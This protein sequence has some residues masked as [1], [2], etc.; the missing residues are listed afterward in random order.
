MDLER[1]GS[2]EWCQCAKEVLR[3]LQCDSEWILLR[4]PDRFKNSHEMWASETFILIK[5]LNVALKGG[6]KRKIMVI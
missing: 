6:W 5:K 1:Y 3:V 4:F 2:S